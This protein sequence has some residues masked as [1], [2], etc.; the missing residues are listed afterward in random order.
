[1][2]EISDSPVVDSHCHPF[3]PEKE[4][5]PFE[6][7][8]NLAANQIQ[9]E[10][11]VNTFLYRQVI[12]ELAR[13]L[14]CEGSHEEVVEVRQKR[15]RR[16]PVEYIRSLF[17][18]AGIETVLIDTGYPYREFA[19]YSITPE[20]FSAIV[21]CRVREICRIDNIIHGLIKD[22]LP[23]EMAV[24]RFHG[25]VGNAVKKGAVS[26]KSVVAYS[27]GLEIRRSAE[28]DAREAYGELL[29]EWKSGRSLREIFYSGSVHAKTVMDH[30][31]FLGV[32]DSV[33]LG[34]PFQLH[35]G[36][37]NPSLLD[38]RKTNPI[39]LRNLINDESTRDARLIITHG[40]YPYIE[41]AGF[42]VNA[43]P[44]VFIDF[45]LITPFVS[46][47]VKEKLLSLFEMAPT[48]KIMYG[49]DGHKIPELFWFSAISA[50]RALSAALNELMESRE[51]SEKWA[52]EVAEQ[53]LHVNA[54]RIYR[55]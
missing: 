33:K 20:E 49:S 9:R 24:D 28:G 31:V 26:L 8:L 3:L 18:D 35:T 23:F 54:K 52:S 32:E 14:E 36:I 13:V 21:P 4:E 50:K 53:I 19:G 42:L 45:S 22:Q 39:L 46:I 47:G 48:T 41:E 1:M 25:H 2:L 34:V 29:S 15:Y 43:H 40:G 17:E 6:R 12:R 10:D 51:I 44:N 27:T 11:L 16:E 30:F 7:H 5:G 38:L 55:P 37:G